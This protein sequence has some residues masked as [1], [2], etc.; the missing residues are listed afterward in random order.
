MLSRSSPPVRALAVSSSCLAE[1]RGRVNALYFAT[2]FAGGAIGSGLSDWCY[3]HYRWPAVSALGAGFPTL[4]LIYLAA[5][6]Q[7]ASARCRM[8]IP[9]D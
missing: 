7:P 2:F 4:A 9:T 8:K 6:R 1:Q 5:E 3:I